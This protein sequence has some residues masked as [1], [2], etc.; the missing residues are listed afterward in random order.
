MS[1]PPCRACEKLPK[2]PTPSPP[3]AKLPVANADMAERC[4]DVAREAL[5]LARMPVRA[6]GT[7]VDWG[8][9][10]MTAWRCSEA[11]AIQALD[12]FLDIGMRTGAGSVNHGSM[13]AHD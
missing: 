4:G 12:E 13:L 8:S 6:D 2:L 9:P 11:A 10:L 3:P 5:G 7:V 1:L